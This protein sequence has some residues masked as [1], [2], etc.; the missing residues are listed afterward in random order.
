[1][2]PEPALGVRGDVPFRQRLSLGLTAIGSA[3]AAVAAGGVL[4]SFL[5]DQP[6]RLGYYALVASGSA[7]RLAV[8]A[9][10]GCLAATPGARALGRRRWLSRVSLGV[11]VLSASL[12][13]ANTAEVLLAAKTLGISVS[14]KDSLLGSGEA[15][16]PVAEVVTFF[17]RDD[18][19]L[20]ADLYRPPLNASVT[21]V[22]ALV[23]VHGG[24]WFMGDKGEN[25]AWNRWLAER[26]FLVLDIQYRLASTADWRQAVS[27]IRCGLAWIRRHALELRADPDRVALLGR[28]A[29][30][31][32]ALLAAYTEVDTG[33]CGDTVRPP[34]AVVAM[35]GPTDLASTYTDA[36][37]TVG[38]DVRHGL[39]ALL[40]DVPSA[41]PVAYREASPINYVQRESPRTL[42]IHGAWDDAVPPEQSRLLARAL[43][44][45]GVPTELV[46]VPAARHAF[47]IV[48]DSLASQL[49]QQA[50]RAF[51]SHSSVR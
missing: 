7:P 33:L 31:H 47:D 2:R 4:L 20:H 38:D 17:R 19:D 28:S 15:A 30:A 48:P 9:L 37:G 12:T 32:L 5:G 29:G 8:I 45:A 39:R 3:C 11:S 42:L 25:V 51:L 18:R 6:G 50:V 35:Y 34:S 49:A 41:R 23:V 13:A 26:G 24:A 14:L 44:Q 36:Q 43:E 27:D 10:L 22:P 16:G 21:A 46:L 1:L 40:G